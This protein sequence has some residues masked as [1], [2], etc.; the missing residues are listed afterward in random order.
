[1]RDKWNDAISIYAA[2]NQVGAQTLVEQTNLCSVIEM[3][4]SIPAQPSTFNLKRGTPD[5]TVWIFAN[6]GQ[7]TQITHGTWFRK[8]DN[9]S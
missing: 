5:V 3:E 6:G 1:M 9:L 2:L 7:A 4:N 8:L